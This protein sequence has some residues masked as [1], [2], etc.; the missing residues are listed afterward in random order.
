[1]TFFFFGSSAVTWEVPERSQAETHLRLYL[2]GDPEDFFVEKAQGLS[3]DKTCP[4]SEFMM[5]PSTS[6]G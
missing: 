6:S 5:M 2:V 4:H 1:M 3:Y